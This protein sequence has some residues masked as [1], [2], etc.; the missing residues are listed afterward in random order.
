MKGLLTITRKG[1]I[2]LLL[3]LFT[4][5]NTTDDIDAIFKGQTWYLTYI[6]TG[7]EQ[8]TPKE[9]QLYSINFKNDKFE[10]LMPNG[11]TIKGTWH[12]DGDGSHTF[13]CKNIEK[14]GIIIGDPIAEKMYSIISNAKGYDGDTNWLQI[15]QDKNTYMQFYNR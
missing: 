10:A 2:L 7:S 13:Y 15:K 11:A 8:T 12:A 6:K 14:N 4:S 3:T 9:G 1:I 5:C